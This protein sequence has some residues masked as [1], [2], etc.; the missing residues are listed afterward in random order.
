M[1][2]SGNRRDFMKLITASALAPAFRGSVEFSQAGDTAGNGFNPR[3]EKWGVQEIALRSSKSYSNP[4]Q[5]GRLECRF[6]SGS[7]EVEAEGF[8][9]GD[10]HWKVRLMPT[11]EGEWTFKTSS[12]DSDLNGKTGSFLCT[13]PR[14]GNHGPVQ[15]QN[16]Y[17]FGYADGTPF[18]VLGTTLYN[19]I[20][21]EEALQ[22]RTLETLKK[23]PFDKVRFCIFPKWYAYNRV[24]PPLYPYVKIGENQFDFERFNP[25]YF[26]HIEQRLKDLEALG[27]QANLILFHPYDKWGVLQ[28]ESSAG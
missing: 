4:F 10:N 23:S 15:V 12:N 11:V 1:K 27:I 18:F 2:N 8:Y 3:V 9:D 13:P 6:Q 16:Q 17:H 20:H 28:N 19:W 5:E 22:R 7:H 25:A 14:A 24:E 21:R 26:R